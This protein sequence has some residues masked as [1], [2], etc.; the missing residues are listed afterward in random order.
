MLGGSGDDNIVDAVGDNTISAGDGNDYVLGS[1]TVDGNVG[2]DDLQGF[3]TTVLRGGAGHD[4]V[5]CGTGAQRVDYNSTTD[6]DPSATEARFVNEIVFDFNRNQGDRFDV[7]TIDA[8]ENIGGNQAFT[9]VGTAPVDQAGE[10]GI[11]VSGGVTYVVA[12]TNGALGPRPAGPDVELGDQC[13]RGFH[14]L[15]VGWRD[16]TRTAAGGHLPALPRALTAA[17]RLAVPRGDQAI[18]QERGDDRGIDQRLRRPG[19][20]HHDEVDRRQRP[21]R[22]RPSGAGAARRGRPAGGSW[23]C[24]R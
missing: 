5:R 19:L 1:G 4:H 7:A 8:N 20:D 13:G 14:S 24:W 21:R 3:G 17:R 11:L 22:G 12:E 15:G 10:I 2:D 23:R 18:A 9:F 6:D 16:F